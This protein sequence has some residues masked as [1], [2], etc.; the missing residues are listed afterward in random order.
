MKPETVARIS[1]IRQKMIEGTATLEELQEG[2]TLMREDR[3]SQAATGSTTAKGKSA[4]PKAQIGSADDM[5]DEL[6]KI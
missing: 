6:G 3:K 5:L 1:Q 4:K 2:V